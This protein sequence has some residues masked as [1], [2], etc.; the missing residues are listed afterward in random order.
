VPE[1]SLVRVADL[2]HPAASWDGADTV[3]VQLQQPSATALEAAQ[4]AR[5]R[6]LR[7][8]ADGVPA[9][10]IRAELLAS[11]DVIRANATEA[12][13]IAGEEEAT[14]EQAWH[15]G[16]ELFEFSD[17]EVVDPTGA[18]DAFVA[19]LIS[20]LRDGA[21]PPQAGRRASAGASATVQRLGGR[22]DLSE[23]RA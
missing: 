21:S 22:P 4:R 7:V 3:S 13:L 19:G 16:S 10:Q 20:A 8:V 11:V 12:A 14:V 6:G 18:G 9:P 2:D 23:L 1:S 5:Q 15:G 17:V